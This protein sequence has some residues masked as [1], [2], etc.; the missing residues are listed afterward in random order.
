[1][2]TTAIILLG[3]LGLFAIL[4][5]I[6]FVVKASARV[7]TGYGSKSATREASPYGSLSK[8][9]RSSDLSVEKIPSSSKPST[10]SKISD[11]VV[12]YGAAAV[13]VASLF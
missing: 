6:Y 12:K 3:L 11:N 2:N 7:I 9:P 5:V 10:S 8:K 13:T 1:M 4:A